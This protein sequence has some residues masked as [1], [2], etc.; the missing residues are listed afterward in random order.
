MAER[1]PPVVL[2]FAGNDASGGAGLAADIQAL[3]A[4]GCHPAP[5]VTAITVQDTT[6]V[7]RAEPVDTELV[8][9]QARAVLDDLSV[10]IIK[11][12]LLMNADIVRCIAGLAREY[13]IPLV[14]D[15]VMQSGGG[16]A[17]ADNG[18]IDAYLH[19]LLP[20]ALLCTPNTVEVYALDETAILSSGCDWTLVTGGHNTGDRI[21]HQLYHRDVPVRSFE[22]ARLPGEFH[23]TGCTL[24]SACAAGIA[25]GQPVE[26][27][28]A[29]ALEYTA[30]TVET[31]FAL[32]KGQLIPNRSP[33]TPG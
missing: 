24:A 23:G 31:A 14:V 28:V 12:G 29:G 26:L 15:P 27:A 1:Q 18:I 10:S 3:T 2:V 32:G 25:H 6:G 11:T 13:S 17:M 30:R 21:E 33:H 9:Q 7:V 8:M 5:V 4:N 16:Q 20:G 22:L 19:E